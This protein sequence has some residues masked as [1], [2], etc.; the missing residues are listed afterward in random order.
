[1]IALAREAALAAGAL[2]RAA[3]RQGGRDLGTQHKGAVDLVTEVDLAC[4]ARVI[5]ILTKG[6]PE[7]PIL[8]EEGGGAARAG[9][10][11]IIDPLDG[12]TNFVHGLPHFAVSIGLQVEGRMQ[13]GVVY[14]PTRDE[15]YEAEAGQ[16]ARLNGAPIR[17]SAVPA[18]DQALVASGFPYDRRG[19]AARYLRYVQ[20]FLERAQGFRRAGAAALDFAWVACGRLDACWEFGLKPW[21]VAAGTLL[22]EEAGGRVSDMDGRPLDIDAPRVLGSNG[23]LHA[24]MQEVL[25]PLLA[26]DQ[27][28]EERWASP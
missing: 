5:E 1:M 28:D 26:R 6:A 27:E 21:D 4:E 18:L 11:W 15:L 25:A 9:T 3:W 20:A 23:I 22:I 14:D 10:R 2:Q 8:A 7:I 13:L 12:T 17:V 24:A 16:G 19:K